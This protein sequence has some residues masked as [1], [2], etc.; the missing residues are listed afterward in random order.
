MDNEI[1]NTS[2]C[3]DKTAYEAMQ[4]IRREERSR[5]IEELKAV[6]N[7]HGYVITSRIVLK[8]MKDCEV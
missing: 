5:L 6:A 2:S 8:E 4:N 1:K 3:T 7:E